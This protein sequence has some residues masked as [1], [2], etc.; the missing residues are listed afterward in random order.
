M[1]PLATPRAWSSGAIS[2]WKPAPEPEITLLID[3]IVFLL[4]GRAKDSSPLDISR[5]VALT[6]TEKAAAR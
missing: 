6:F 1:A 4:L 2:S 5:L 3:R